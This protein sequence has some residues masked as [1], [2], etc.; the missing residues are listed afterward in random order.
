M[1]L[2][3]DVQRFL[4]EV[5]ERTDDPATL[6]VLFIDLDGFKLV[7]DG[8]GHDAGDELLIEVGTRLRSTLRPDDVVA[9]VG[10]DEFVVV[11]PWTRGP[12]EVTHLAERILDRVNEPVVT[13]GTAA[14]VACSIG[15]A[16]HDRQPTTAEV[17]IGNADLAMYEAKRA[18]G[19]RWEL[20]GEELR[21]TMTRRFEVQRAIN[22]GLR[23][24]EFSLFLQ[25][26]CDLVTGDAVAA[27]CL[28]RWHHPERGL[29]LPAQFVPIAEES[30][31]I[32][33]LGRWILDEA[34]RITARIV[35]GGRDDF[36][37]SV[38]ISG[39]QLATDG[40]ADELFEML[41]RHDLE[42]R[43]LVLEVTETVFVDTDL[44]V[45]SVL[46]ELTAAGTTLALD[47]FGTGYSSLN[48]LRVMPVTMLKV[49]S[50]YTADLGLQAGTTA[51]METMVELSRRLGLEL[52]VEGIETEE[53]LAQVCEMGLR[54][55]PGI[56]PR[57]ALRRGR[58]LRASRGGGVAAIGRRLSVARSASARSL[59]E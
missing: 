48:H 11:C 38:N 57:S 6:A 36:R 12:D 29:V 46:E 39:R 28:V 14:S 35:G 5:A 44:S 45:M 32:V 47:D 53:Q 42:P 51:I 9:R 24:D 50:S 43:H 58:V 20:Y 30:D 34:C 10:G 40:F 17:L 18:G 13:G 56:P 15:I 55:R 37:V 59:L 31:L 16:L 1:A 33:T 4:D 27:E 2:S 49:D 41:D 8:L 21:S 25:P 52:V 23:N 7:N 22:G 3:D 26:M 19:A 54:S